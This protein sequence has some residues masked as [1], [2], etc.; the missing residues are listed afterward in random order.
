MLDRYQILRELPENESVFKCHSCRSIFDLFNG[1]LPIF[2]ALC[3]KEGVICPICKSDSTEL[4]CKVDAYSIYLKLKGFKCR[5]GQP[6]SGVDICPVCCTN[7][8]PR[9]FNHECLSLSRVTGYMSDVSGWNAAKK[10]ELADRKRYKIDK[11]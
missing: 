5:D 3:G 11:N 9:C 4:L 7:M 1:D 8:C 2:M 6:I 10:Q